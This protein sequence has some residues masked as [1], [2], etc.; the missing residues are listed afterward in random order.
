[1]ISVKQAQALR[2]QCRKALGMSEE[3]YKTMLAGYGVTSS[4]ALAP[5]DYNTLMRKLKGEEAANRR[6]AAPSDKQL[7]LIYHLWAELY[8]AGKVRH[9][10]KSAPLHWMRK[11][12]KRPDGVIE[13]S[14]AQ[15]SRCIE[16]LKKWLE[17]D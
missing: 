15:K 4:K 14:P 3:D 13:F 9:K 8:R 12:L 10:E 6:W 2:L 11:Y 7:G 5:K 17:R 16:R 1:M